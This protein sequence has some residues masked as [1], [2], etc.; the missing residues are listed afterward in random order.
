MRTCR[1]AGL[2]VMDG[3]ERGMRD[4]SPQHVN[5]SAMA[6]IDVMD[7]AVQSS[8]LCD[9][10][11][12]PAETISEQRED[13][14]FVEGCKPVDAITIAPSNECRVIG[15]PS[16]DIAI[17]PATKLVECLRQIPMIK[18][19]P[20]LDAGLKKRIDQSVVKCQSG[21]VRS[22]DPVGQDTRP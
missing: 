7:G 2:P 21:L 22:A 13:A 15:K 4:D 10:R 12:I 5:G 3:A 19:Y 6:E 20:R 14:R 11:C 16:C 8:R 9:P 17:L 18:T 1:K